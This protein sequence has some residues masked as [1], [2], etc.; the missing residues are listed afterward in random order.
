ME[1]EI[2]FVKIKEAIV[3]C[4]A[5]VCVDYVSNSIYEIPAGQTKFI[6]GK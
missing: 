4:I 5:A 6:M 2:M 3:S 1:G